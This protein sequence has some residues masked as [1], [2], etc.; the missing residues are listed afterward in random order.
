LVNRSFHRGRT[1]DNAPFKGKPEE[2]S[3]LVLQPLY[4]PTGI[5]TKIE[6]RIEVSGDQPILFYT[7]GNEEPVEIMRFKNFQPEFRYMN[8]AGELTRFWPPRE[9]EQPLPFDLSTSTTPSVLPQGVVLMD[10]GE[11]ATFF[12]YVSVSNNTL[13]AVDYAL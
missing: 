9:V 1:E 3:G 13:A 12:W 4:N 2:I 11:E 7:Q 10:T 5:P 8:N 6:W